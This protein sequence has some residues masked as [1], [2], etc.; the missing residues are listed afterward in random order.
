MGR[1]GGGRWNRLIHERFLFSEQERQG[2]VWYSH[3]H[4]HLSFVLIIFPF[5]VGE[6]RGISLTKISG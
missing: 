6:K 3:Q 2:T 5:G 4:R 1:C